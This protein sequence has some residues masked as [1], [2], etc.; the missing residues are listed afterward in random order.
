LFEDENFI[1]K[2]VGLG[3]LSMANSSPNTNGSQF[4]L[5]LVATPWLDNKHVVFG[6]V[7]EGYNVLKAMEAIG[8]NSG[9]VKKPV[10]IIDCGQI[11]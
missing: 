2:H 8:S 4:F 10:I 11:T 1:R 5:C 3:I 7:H 6:Q 9:K